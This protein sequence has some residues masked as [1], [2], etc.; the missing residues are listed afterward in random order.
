VIS[1]PPFRVYL[2]K[3]VPGFCYDPPPPPAPGV[4]PAAGGVA[5]VA[6]VA[7]A[8][9]GVA[10]GV[11]PG[12][13]PAPAGGMGWA[14][15]VKLCAAPPPELL[16]CEHATTCLLATSMNHAIA[17][18]VPPVPPPEVPTKG[19]YGSEPEVPVEGVGV[20][21]C[22]RARDAG[23]ASVAMRRDKGFICYS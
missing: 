21:V 10:G 17:P 3:I 7:P 2:R 1:Q 22:A 6:G 5:G 18:E 15:Q 23:I 14:V 8:A 12:V 13:A 20:G 16:D 9:G 19:M 4:A 11:A